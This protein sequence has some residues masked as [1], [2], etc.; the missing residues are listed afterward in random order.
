M[1]ELYNITF[2]ALN[3]YYTVLEKTGYIKD[4]DTNK[5]L[6]LTF[7]SEFI[8]DYKDYITEEDYNLISRI[9]QCASRSSCL[10]PYIQYQEMS[11][12]IGEYISDIPT[13]I[14]EVEDVRYSQAQDG[15][16]LVNQ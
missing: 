16:R 9:I 13:R 10:V 2:Q 14:S 6:L 1:D 7:L 8:Q 11:I 5:V 3:R 15:I 4:K 12:P